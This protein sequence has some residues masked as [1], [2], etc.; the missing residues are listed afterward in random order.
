VPRT[1]KAPPAPTSSDDIREHILRFLYDKQRTG[2]GVR[3][4]EVGIRQLKQALKGLGIGG[5][6]VASNLNFLIDAGW[7]LEKRRT[8]TVA[9]KKGINI[10]Q[11]Q[12]KYKVSDKGV[13]H[14][15]G[16][17]RF[18]PTRAT[19]GINVTNIQGIT[20]IGD[21]NLV[22]Y[23]YGDLFRS[24]DLL[25]EEVRKSAQLTDE[26]KLNYQAEIETIK[27]QLGKPTPNRSIVR[28]AWSA[29]GALATV[30]GV[31]QF[32]ERVAHLIAP[33]VS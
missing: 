26:E 31:T 10:P 21:G 5:T 7:V 12:V 14:F 11:E 29:L 32:F 15:E 8:Y 3:S 6:D 23:L 18:Q 33:L 13:I 4:G 20:V 28:E 16:P 19:A 24:L 30:G 25:G 17:S 1:K 2:R 27:S 9:T 22:N